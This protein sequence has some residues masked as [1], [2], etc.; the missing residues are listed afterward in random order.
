VASLQPENILVV[1]EKGEIVFKLGD[2]DD[3]KQGQRAVRASDY[4]ASKHL[5]QLY[6]F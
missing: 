3:L 5:L 6:T 2:L 4:L 1:Q